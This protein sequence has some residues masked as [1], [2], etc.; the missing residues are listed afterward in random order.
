MKPSKTSVLS[1]VILTVLCL[2]WK[3]AKKLALSE[4]KSPNNIYLY[5]TLLFVSDDIEGVCLYSV[6]DPATPLFKMRIP[7]QGNTG[8]AVRDS[9]I[10]VNSYNSILVLKYF[11]DSLYKIVKFIK[12]KYYYYN[13][14]PYNY[15]YDDNRSG[16]SCGCSHAEPTSATSKGGDMA[17]NSG[18]PDGGSGGVGGSYATFAVIGSYLY[19]IDQSSLITLDITNPEDPVELSR[20]Y[21]GGGIETLFPTKDYLFIG[22]T[23]GMRVFSRSN[24]ASPH[25]IGSI[26]HFR[27]CDPVV[28]WDTLAYVTLRGGNRCGQTN[29]VLL[30]ISIKDPASP[31]ALDTLDLSTPFG[32]TVQDTL[33]Y[34]SKG[35]S[36]FCLVNAADPRQL[37]VEQTWTDK[38]TKDFIWF[39]DLLYVMGFEDVR[40]MDATAPDTPALLSTIP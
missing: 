18:S 15:G 22:T 37:R 3:P 28:V 24:P 7:M 26:S 1:L 13:N 38:D 2:G 35:D 40:V 30:S 32:L 12:G 9:F 19:H 23:T 34:V 4:L 31:V 11:S 16:L 5:D 27:A 17:W 8:L 39:G 10:F 20:D 29:D 25:Q 6:K 33:L 36:G 21:I 14:G